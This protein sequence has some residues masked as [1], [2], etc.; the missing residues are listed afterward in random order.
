MMSQDTRTEE[1]TLRNTIS[2]AILPSQ[3]SSASGQDQRACG[4]TGDEHCTDSKVLHAYTDTVSTMLCNTSALACLA[5]ELQ[6]TSSHIGHDLHEY[7]LDVVSQCGMNTEVNNAASGSSHL[8]LE[9]TNLATVNPENDEKEMQ[10]KSSTDSINYSTSISP[11]SDN[12]DKV[13]SA[14]PMSQPMKK[15]PVKELTGSQS[16]LDELQRYPMF[17]KPKEPTDKCSLQRDYNT[18]NDVRTLK[19]T[20]YSLVNDSPYLQPHKAGDIYSQNDYP[21]SVMKSTDTSTADEAYS[22]PVGEET[23]SYQEFQQVYSTA[24]SQC[25]GNVGRRNLMNTRKVPASYNNYDMKQPRSSN[26]YLLRASSPANTS[27]W[28]ST[29][30]QSNSPTDNGLMSINYSSDNANKTNLI[31]NYL[32]PFM[33]QE[34]VKALFSSIG[35][36]ESCK[37]V[38]EK[39]TG[40]SLGYA[41]VKYIR[42]ADAEKAIR[43]LNG[44]RLQNKTIKVSLA[45]PSSE[46]I[47]GANLYICGL[48]KKMTQAELEELFNQCGRIIT[49]R[50]LYDNK[51]GLSRGVAFIRFDQRHEAELAIRRLNG[52]QAPPEHPNGAPS[53]PITVKFANSPNS[54]RHDSLSLALLKQAAQLQSVAASVVTP[55]SR[56]AATAAATAVAAAGLL[57]PLQQIASISNRLKYS[58]ALTGGGASAGASPADFLPAMASA[59]AV[60]NPLLAPAVAAS[61][62]ALTATGWC[63]FVYNLAPETEEAN[64]WQLFGPFGA[65][66]TVKIIRD[67]TTNKCKG[68][69]FVTMSNY[70]EALL[71]IHSLNGFALGNRV[72]QVSFKTTPNAKLRP[73]SS[74]TPPP[75]ASPLPTSLSN[76]QH[77]Q[78]SASQLNA[79]IISSNGSLYTS[80]TPPDFGATTSHG[81]QV[82]QPQSQTSQQHLQNP[83]AQQK[84]SPSLNLRSATSQPSFGAP[85]PQTHKSLLV[86]LPNTAAPVQLAAPR[87]NADSTIGGRV[88]K[89]LLSLTTNDAPSEL[90]ESFSGALSIKSSSNN[91]TT[92]T[93]LQEKQRAQQKKNGCLTKNI[94]LG[95]ECNPA[96]LIVHGNQATET[97][98]T[99]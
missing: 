96:L 60:V 14:S 47:K 59:A 2:T 44:L 65:V 13:V 29:A 4:D 70:E 81:Q 99:N 28:L 36:V 35:E 90:S 83:P 50:I 72:L 92:I 5:G 80:N 38:R 91:L 88:Y 61:S 51:T 33:S 12:T 34:E 74:N 76:V 11:C 98:E 55:P 86:Q 10:E 46:S 24:L 93:N 42:A 71:A 23:C 27:E 32:P 8:L 95:A 21:N 69:G 45:R 30:L 64:L 63:I 68:F 75:T 66:Q 49:A 39:A 16:T 7:D 19:N 79:D 17:Q 40:E 97:F 94:G 25:S 31:V 54:I 41:F 18:L 48:P 1:C 15:T 26:N 58:N 89:P 78:S 37:L 77:V 3:S 52:Y 87:S 56:T 53:E 73:P 62:G 9:K 6:N 43:T 82:P 67:P 85:S 20:D 22:Y 57:S 84:L